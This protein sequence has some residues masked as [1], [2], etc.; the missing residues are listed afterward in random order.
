M[1][2]SLDVLKYLFFIKL[3]VTTPARYHVLG[4]PSKASTLK[5]MMPAI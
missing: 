1:L 4:T 5:R 3:Q 2:A